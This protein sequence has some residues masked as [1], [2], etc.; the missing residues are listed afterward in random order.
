MNLHSVQHPTPCCQSKHR[1][2]RHRIFPG[3]SANK[4]VTARRLPTGTTLIT[5]RHKWSQFHTPSS[6]SKTQ[7]STMHS[8]PGSLP[9][10][11]HQIGALQAI[12]HHRRSWHPEAQRQIETVV[13]WKAFKK[14]GCHLCHQASIIATPFTANIRSDAGVRV[15]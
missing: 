6:K 10:T 13:L 9:C 2:Y 11:S 1:T 15:Q 8:R 5:L 3:I 14:K 7:P 4:V 12:P